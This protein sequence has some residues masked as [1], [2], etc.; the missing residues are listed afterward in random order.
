ML[1]NFQTVGLCQECCVV[2]DIFVV[3]EDVP[4]T[5]LTI[6]VGNNI[7]WACLNKTGY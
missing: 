7:F 2:W 6:P 1:I 5:V 3:V 4:G